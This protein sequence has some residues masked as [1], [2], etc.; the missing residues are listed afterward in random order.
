MVWENI[1]QKAE[2]TCFPSTV[3]GPLIIFPD[4]TS[5]LFSYRETVLVIAEEYLWVVTNLC[6][7]PCGVVGMVLSPGQQ[8]R[9][10]GSE[11]KGS[12]RLGKPQAAYQRPVVAAF[13]LLHWLKLWMLLLVCPGLGWEDKKK[14]NLGTSFNRKL[15]LT[16]ILQVFF[17][18]NLAIYQGVI[19]VQAQEGNQARS[20]GVQGWKKK[21][22]LDF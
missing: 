13:L 8:S 2:C 14:C 15:R 20:T 19:I 6:H 17:L 16:E 3:K 21:A 22:P 7:C 5:P 18:E 12:S 9:F 11:Q 4:P 1:T 10:Q